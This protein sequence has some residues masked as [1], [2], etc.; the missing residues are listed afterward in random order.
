[1]SLCE[2]AIRIP[3]LLSGGRRTAMKH[4]LKGGYREKVCFNHVDFAPTTLG[5]CGIEKP[6]WVEGKDFS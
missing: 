1:M 3:A 2:E 6:D 5:L 4:G